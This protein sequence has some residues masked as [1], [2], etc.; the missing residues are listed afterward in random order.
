MVD[1]AI[2]WRA[3]AKRF[4][5]G[6]ALGYWGERL[7]GMLALFADD[8]ATGLS[9]AR[10]APWL[11]EA[12]SP[13]DVLTHVGNERL[14]EKYPGETDATYR[15][16]L[17][18]A[19]DT[20]SKAGN[21]SVII[22]QL[23]AFGLSGITIKTNADWNWDNQPNNW[24][25]FW[26]VITGHPWTWSGTWGD[27]GDWGDG[28]LWGI[29]ATEAQLE[30]VRSII[31]KFRPAHVINPWI[32]FVIDGAQW[33]GTPNGKWDDWRERDAG[34]VYIDGKGQPPVIKTTFT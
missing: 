27:G 30:A 11:A 6:T 31:N 9:E 24:S 26:V 8:T 21:E 14:M 17:L 25:R 18:A 4:L 2:N 34:A 22:A 12:T 13:D 28:R 33:T 32:I 3:Y 19:W 16:R 15:A 20:W 1:A 10:K 7:T 5:P 29:T 23:T